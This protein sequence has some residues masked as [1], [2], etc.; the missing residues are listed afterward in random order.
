MRQNRFGYFQSS[1][2]KTDID[3]LIDKLSATKY[4][5]FSN[6][7]DEAL[8]YEKGILT[9]HP[10]YVS[11]LLSTLKPPDCDL[12]CVLYILGYGYP[13]KQVGADFSQK[14]EFDKILGNFFVY[15]K[16][17]HKGS[18]QDYVDIMTRPRHPYFVWTILCF[19]PIKDW[20]SI[21]NTPKP[22]KRI[23][24][25]GFGELIT[26]GF[27]RLRELDWNNITDQAES[28]L[29]VDLDVGILILGRNKDWGPWPP[30]IRAM[31]NRE[32]E[33]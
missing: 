7:F 32:E 4:V 3:D 24:D 28:F 8:N 11:L 23:R 33:Q 25:M 19:D 18:P 16:P 12:S 9:F 27:P 29:D 5:L 30:E 15:P 21:A 2:N 22:L 6:T 1:E 31:I 17:G 13:A 10:D 26:E 14:Y 20:K